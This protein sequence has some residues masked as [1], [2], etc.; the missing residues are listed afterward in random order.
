MSNRSDTSASPSSSHVRPGRSFAEVARGMRAVPRNLHAPPSTA[1]VLHEGAVHK[2]AKPSKSSKVE[3][4][5]DPG[6]ATPCKAPRPPPHAGQQKETAISNASQTKRKGSKKAANPPEADVLEISSS[7]DETFILADRPLDPGDSMYRGSTTKSRVDSVQQ[8]RERTPVETRRRASLKRRDDDGLDRPT[9]SGDVDPLASPAKITSATQVPRP[10]PRPRP[11]RKTESCPTSPPAQRHVV[12]EADQPR[13]TSH[14]DSRPRRLSEISLGDYHKLEEILA[15]AKR[16]AQRSG[17]S[18]TPPPSNAKNFIDSEA[19]ESGDDASADELRPA[20]DNEYDS[21]DSFID[22]SPQHDYPMS[23]RDDRLD[24]RRSRRPSDASSVGM[25]IDRTFVGIEEPDPVAL[26]YAERERR[27]AANEEEIAA[28]SQGTR[29]NKAFLLRVLNLLKNNKG[30]DPEVPDDEDRQTELAMRDSLL[31]FLGGSAP[32]RRRSAEVSPGPACPS[33]K[34][35]RRA[36]EQGFAA[37]DDSPSDDG[38]SD[39]ER[40]DRKR[41]RAALDLSRR[42]DTANVAT[43]SS[44]HPS[45]PHTPPRPRKQKKT[46]GDVMSSASAM[47]ATPPA[48]SI[49]PTTNSSGH[50]IS[51]R[52]VQAPKVNEIPID[53]SDALVRSTAPN[54]LYALS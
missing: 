50:V 40:C 53:M 31:E 30:I 2:S 34:G 36:F 25:D 12:H 11:R 3:R 43:L 29:K 54:N 4:A 8:T 32:K 6:T 38:L 42:Q 28:T 21:N 48:E 26:A 33:D 24:D 46:M 15:S 37:G 23:D 41:L 19:E 39:Y 49:S 13:R 18:S 5:S 7:E 45:A 44:I 51:S 16:K 52:V 1:K 22:D 9:A 10:R 20:D 47:P 27:H 35:K 14:P 17:Q